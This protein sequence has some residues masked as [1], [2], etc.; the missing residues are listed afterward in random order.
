MAAI[1]LKEKISI[2]KAEYLRL[3]KLEERFR[4]FWEYMEHLSDVKEGREDIK[5]KRLISQELLFKKLGF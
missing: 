2:P 4:G 3:K 5:K 1:A